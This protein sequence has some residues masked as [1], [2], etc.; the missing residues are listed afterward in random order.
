MEGSLWI[1]RFNDGTYAVTFY[2][3]SLAPSPVTDYKL[4][5]LAGL[6]KFLSSINVAL[7]EEQMGMLRS[8]KTMVINNLNP[9]DDILKIYGAI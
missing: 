4:L 3:L 9:P 8:T 1:I 5:D 6:Y 7:T 2:P